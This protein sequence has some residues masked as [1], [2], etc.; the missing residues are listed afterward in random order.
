MGETTR[1]F[2]VLST[3]G[4][5][6]D[7]AMQLKDEGN[8][9]VFSV[10]E[11]DYSKIGEGILKKDNDWFNYLEKDYIFLIDGCENGK[12]QTY[13]RDRGEFVFGNGGEKSE[14]IENDRQV[15]QKLFKEAGFRQPYSQN[16]SGKNAFD[17]AIQF[18]QK[19]K[20]TKFILKQNADAPKSL[21][22]AGKFDGNEDMLFHLDGLKKS[23]NEAEFGEINF[24]LMEMVE[25]MEVAISA[26]FNGSEFMKNKKGKIVAF[27]NFEEKKEA[28]GGLGEV[29]G[30]LGTTFIGTTEDHPLVKEVMIRPEIIKKLKDL[31]YRG[32]VDLN[33]SK[34]SKG[35]VVFEMTTRPGIPASSYEFIEG[36]NMPTGEMIEL[37]AKGSDFPIEI[38]EGLGMVMVVAAKPFP[39]DVSEKSQTSLGE[40][41][42][43]LKNGKPIKEFTD[44]QKKHIHLENFEKSDGIYRVAT[45]N[46]YL[47]TVTGTGRTIKETR[48]KLI[49]YIKDNLYVSGQKWRSDIGKRIEEYESELNTY[50]EESS[51]SLMPKK[52]ELFIKK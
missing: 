23:W 40:R 46:G 19:N 16:F 37:V 8:E 42:W 43:I 10:P 11:K 21:N 17:E 22:H 9:V 24:D 36:L 49:K 35:Y 31:N 25:G 39:V 52:R 2:Y 14:E 1:K 48:D 13:L 26:F 33:G 6:L 5:L 45:K 47:L 4:E 28:D 34:T 50:K 12:L 41:L 29:T 18:I 38:K 51:S 44:E 15:G 30:E 7:V 32:V 20:D 3:Y 27:I